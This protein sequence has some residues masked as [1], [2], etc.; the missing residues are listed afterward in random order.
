MAN[1]LPSTSP[2][3]ITAWTSIN[4][5]HTEG[6]QQTV[7]SILTAAPEITNYISLRDASQEFRGAQ[8][9]L[10]II[11]AQRVLATATDS[12]VQAM[13]SEVI[14][15]NTLNLIDLDMELNLYKYN[16][17]IAPNAIYFAIFTIV[18]AYI[19][20][21]C[22]KS[23]YHWYNVTYFC[24]Y[25]LEFCGWLGRILSINDTQESA[26][27][28]L[29]FVALTL[30]PAF[31]MAGVYF[32][33]AQMVVIHGRQYS[34]LKPLWYS[35]FF[36]TTDVLSLLV[37]AG[38]G[39]SASIASQNYKDTTPGTNGV[40][41]GIAIQTFA[42]SVFIV[43]YFEFL[44]RVYFKHSSEVSI[45]SP[46]KKRSFLNFFKLLFHTKSVRQYKRD[47]LDQFYNPRFQ[48][49][50]HSK[51]FPYMPLAITVT[52]LVIYIRCVYRVVELAEGWRG[53]LMVHE[54]YIMV[55]DALMIAIAGLI[56]IPFHPYWALGKNN[57]VKLATIRKRLDVSDSE[58][59]DQPEAPVDTENKEVVQD[60]VDTNEQGQDSMDKEIVEESIDRKSSH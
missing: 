10:Q 2:T 51:L 28:T 48:Y 21:M 27:F 30:G 44:N 8:A 5:T 22:I 20:A 9:S 60:S 42:M 15:N 16:L 33:F 50:R 41:A 56:S 57:N 31:I 54:V 52:V 43:F 18:F 36:I 49:I 23:K 47:H 55:L 12:Q 14:S 4:P 11:S 37:Q 29:Q 25:G 39:A 1:W 6:L 59:E 53:Y 26:Y 7:S 58:E 46:Y 35:Y 38:G 3:T 17:V 13:A 24:G 45:D 19:A 32:L 34:L 40:I